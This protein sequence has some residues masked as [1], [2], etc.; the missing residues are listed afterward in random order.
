MTD[1]PSRKRFRAD[2]ESAGFTPTDRDFEAALRTAR[3]LA[4]C[5]AMVAAYVEVIP[6][7]APR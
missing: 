3:F 1:K 2:L 6:D 5:A 7:D 4:A